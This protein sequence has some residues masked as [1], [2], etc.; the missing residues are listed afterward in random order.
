MKRIWKWFK[1]FLQNDLWFQKKLHEKY[2]LGKCILLNFHFLWCV[3]TDGCSPEEYLWF[4]FYHKDRRE[5]KTFLT[6]LRH[7]RLQRKYNSEKVRTILNDKQAFNHFFEKELGREWLDADCA[8][9]EEI[10]KFLNKH[11]TVFV[12]PKKGGCG[13]GVFKYYFQGEKVDSQKFCGCLLEQCIEQHPL[14]K[15]FNPNVVNTLRIGTFCINGKAEVFAAGFRMGKT[16][17]CVDN[18]S[19]GGICSNI[20]ICHGVVDSSGID[21]A[22]ARFERNPYSGKELRG[23]QIPYWNEA[24]EMVIHASERLSD[25]NI[26]GWDV[27]VMEHGPVLVEGNPD[28]GTGVIQMCD[29]IGKYPAIQKRIREKWGT[30]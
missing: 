21:G 20:Q 23:F 8:K 1:E 27:A 9:E 2:S 10:A 25:S 13:K 4:E 24:K 18:L 30:H 17:A 22:L 12:K 28:Q 26:V 3:L 19:S 14:F 7:A 15:E 6:Y 29:V 11:K 16:E 5:R